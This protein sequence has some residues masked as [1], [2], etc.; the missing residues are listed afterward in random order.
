MKLGFSWWD[1]EHMV[2]DD[3]GLFKPDAVATLRISVTPTA[4]S[5]FVNTVGVGA[6]EWDPDS[7]NNFMDMPLTVGS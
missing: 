3:I 7:S 6:H 5:S 2:V 4:A 1:G